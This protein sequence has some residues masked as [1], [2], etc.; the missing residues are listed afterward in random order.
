MTVRWPTVVVLGIM[1]LVCSGFDVIYAGDGAV[2]S[3][4]FLLRSLGSTLVIMIVVSRE[5]ETGGAFAATAT[6]F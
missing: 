5:R 6:F 2:S 1:L 4:S 3:D